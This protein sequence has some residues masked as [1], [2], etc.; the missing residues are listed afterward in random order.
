MQA[1]EH[2]VGQRM[3]HSLD[4]LTP[5]RFCSTASKDTVLPTVNM[6]EQGI[7][8]PAGMRYVSRGAIIGDPG[9]LISD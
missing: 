4:L 6:G 9:S 8:I 2:S 3:L 5:W 1:G 7:Y